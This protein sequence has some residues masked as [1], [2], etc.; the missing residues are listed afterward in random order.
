M[1]AGFR[2]NNIDP[3]AR[4]C[5]AS[6][7]AGFYQTFGMDEPANHYG[8]IELTDTMVL[9]GNNMA[10][11]HPVLWSRV[12]GRKQANPNTKVICLTTF[13]HNTAALSDDVIVFKPSTDLAIMNYPNCANLDHF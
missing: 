3:N 10:E 9:W 2:S 12:L 8:D 11:V 7:V 5:M 13:R 1:K 6:S 4:L